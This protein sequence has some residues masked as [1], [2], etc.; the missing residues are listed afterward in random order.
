MFKSLAALLAASS[1]SIPSYAYHKPQIVTV[2]MLYCPPATTLMNGLKCRR[3]KITYDCI[4]D[5]VTYP[6]G[7]GHLIDSNK[8]IS[9]STCEPHILN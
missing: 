8:G 3:Y 1:L 6:L 9:R 4:K 2:E 7:D 5:T